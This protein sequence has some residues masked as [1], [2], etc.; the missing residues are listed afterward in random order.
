MNGTAAGKHGDQT[1]QHKQQDKNEE[2]TTHHG[3]IPFRLEG[4]YG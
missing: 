3:E 4:E 1:K 2:N